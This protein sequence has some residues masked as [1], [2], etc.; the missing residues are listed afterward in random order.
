MQTVFWATVSRETY[1]EKPQTLVTLNNM[2]TERGATF[3]EGWYLKLANNDIPP[4]QKTFTKLDEDFHQAFIPKDLEG[5]A[6]QEVN[7]LTMEQFRGD[8]DQYS[9]AFRLAQ[10]WSGIDL[11]SILVDALQ[12]G[13]S[14]QLAIM[15]TT[16]VLPFGQEKTGWKW[17]QWLNKAGEFYRNVVRL[18]EIRRRDDNIIPRSS[19]QKWTPFWKK[20]PVPDPDAMDMDWINLSPYNRRH[21]IKENGCFTC[22]KPGCWPWKNSK[23]PKRK[24]MVGEGS[25]QTTSPQW[26]NIP[27][28]SDRSITI[29]VELY[30]MENGTI[31][32]TTALIDSGET[33][34]CIDHDMVRRMKWPLE[35]LHRPMYTQN[36]DGTNNSR[37]MI[38]HQVKLCYNSFSLLFYLVDCTFFLLTSLER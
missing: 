28:M 26:T 36:A 7:S 23:S 33:I 13:V 17:E 24:R 37:G 11:D 38:Q 6:C 5:W 4:N 35:K 34:C 16:S 18:Q 12:W 21:H 2:S 1:D 14:N 31:A 8:F 22:H 27:T 32:K 25:L 9:S 19:P 30:K 29:L 3:T 20:T 15:M 10:A